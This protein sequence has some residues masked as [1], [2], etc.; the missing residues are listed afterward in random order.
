MWSSGYKNIIFRSLKISKGYGM[1]TRQ[2]LFSQKLMF[3]SKKGE[4]YFTVRLR[5]MQKLE[6]SHIVGL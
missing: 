3:F 1:I 5:W 4:N 6:M 2:Y